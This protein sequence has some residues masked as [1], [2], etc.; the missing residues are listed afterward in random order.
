MAALFRLDQQYVILVTDLSGPRRNVVAKPFAAWD[1]MDSAQ[2]MSIQRF[3]Q[4][5]SRVVTLE[6]CGADAA[7]ISEVRASVSAAGV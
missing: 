6:A 7:A 1:R 3:S 2:F 4:I 5:F